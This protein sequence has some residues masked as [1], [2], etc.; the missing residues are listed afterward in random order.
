MPYKES[1]RDSHLLPTPVSISKVDMQQRS[2]RYELASDNTAGI[3]PEALA[4]LEKA[5][6]GSA[7]SY[8]D[9]Q[10]TA[11][12]RERI[13]EI[14]ERDCVA[15]LVFNGTAANALA[16][17]Q[18]CRSFYSILCHANAHIQTDEC[19]APE[20]FTK[21]SKLLPVGGK[22]G[23]ID[24]GQAET[25]IARQPELHAHKPRAISVTQ[26]TELGTVYRLEELGAV[27][28]LARKHEMFLH[29]DGARFANAIAALGCTPKQITWQLGIDVLCFGGTKNGVAAGELVVFFKKE[30]AR[31]FDYRLKQAGQLAS[32][33]R[34]LA[35]PWL[36]LLEGET[37][38][39]NARHAN[40]M[41]GRL[42]ER[43]Q[44]E[45]GLHTVFP[46]EAS[47]VF[48]Q[49][50]EQMVRGLQDCGWHFHKFI[51]PDIYRIMCSWSSTDAEI[52]AFIT[53]VCCIQRKLT[54]IK[55]R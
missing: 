28:E 47:A 13:C 50:D 9:D 2:G 19:G 44:T 53:D 27:A 31:E 23:K 29:M 41:A 8:G 33:M 55:T 49:L 4:A 12:L 38:L 45:A 16:L 20:F 43:L 26:S 14:F 7:A 46:V 30:L 51:E 32:K 25:I 15:H 48:V 1:R 37:W 21:G 34:F 22:N 54:D 5:N 40:Q 36:G 35:A 10:W 39:R 42:A 6:A 18:L 52:N 11:R 3:C 24:L 17:A